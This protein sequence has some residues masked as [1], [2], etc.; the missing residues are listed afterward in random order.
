MVAVAADSRAQL[1]LFAE[2]AATPGDITEDPRHD[3]PLGRP[4]P[5]EV[6]CRLAH[7]A[8][9]H[10][11]YLGIGML[12]R[13]GDC[14]YDSAVLFGPSGEIDLKYRRIQPQWHGRDAD[15]EVY[16]EGSEMVVAAT[17]IGRFCFALCGDLF[18][19][20]IA[21]RIKQ[22]CPD[23]VLWLVARNFSDGSFCQERWDREEECEYVAVA[24]STGATT[25]MVNRLVDPASSAYPSF[26]GAFVTSR[27][28]EVTA[29]LPLARPGVFYVDVPD[30][31]Q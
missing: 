20:E 10:G 6:T 12:E 11:L 23:Y 30:P 14:L 15:P 27:S 3:L 8:K 7:V 17:A 22:S 2:L 29:C 28:G 5:G 26:G 19:V 31:V 13:E 18:D 1:V 24:A 25:L 16:R 9:T 21:A 4:I